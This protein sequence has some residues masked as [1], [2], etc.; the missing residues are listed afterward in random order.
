MLTLPPPA[1]SER[2]DELW[3]H[4]CLE[5]FVR[6]LDGGYYEMN[7][8]PS[9]HWAAYR[10]EGYRSGMGPAEMVAPRIEA[11]I[12]G[13]DYELQAEVDLGGLSD[14]SPDGPWRLGLSAVLEDAR[15]GIS[16]WALSHPAGKPDF[17]HPD[18]FALELPLT[19]RP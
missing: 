5:A 12:A 6:S 8:A 17:H 15:G 19:D 3:R 11:R 10:F 2:R 4:T 18:S 7:F 13:D 14:I 1:P 9:T 16:Y